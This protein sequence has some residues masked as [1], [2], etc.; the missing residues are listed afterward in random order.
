[1]AYQTLTLKNGQI[2]TFNE[3]NKSKCKYCRCPIWWGAT[4]KAKTLP[5]QKNSQGEWISHMGNCS[6]F[7]KH[8]DALDDMSRQKTRDKWS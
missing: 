3:Q 1:M 2:V 5:I 6:A 8:E 4:N 7:E